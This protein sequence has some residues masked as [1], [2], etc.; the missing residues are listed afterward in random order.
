MRAGRVCGRTSIAGVEGEVSEMFGI[1]EEAVLSQ[2]GCASS[3]CEERLCESAEVHE[4][5]RGRDGT[6]V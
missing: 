6:L 4:E 2:Y 1:D 5:R 3:Y